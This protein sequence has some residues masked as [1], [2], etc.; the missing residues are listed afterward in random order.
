MF[1]LSKPLVLIGS[2]LILLVSTTISQAQTVSAISKDLLVNAPR[3]KVGNDYYSVQLEY[4]E[5]KANASSNSTGH[6]GSHWRVTSQVT[7]AVES[8]AIS[9]EFNGSVLALHCAIYQGAAYSVKLQLI[10]TDSDTILLQ[11]VKTE[12][13][14]GCSGL[15]SELQFSDSVLAGCVEREATYSGWVHPEQVTGIS[16]VKSG[17]SSTAGIEKLV[18]LRYLDLTGNQLT[19]IDI[20]SNINLTMLMLSDNRLT[21]LNIGSASNLYI[22]ELDHNQLN[23]IDVSTNTSLGVLDLASNRLTEIAIGHNKD[24]YH[25]NLSSNQLSE[26][27]IGENKDLEYLNLSSNRLTEIN[28]SSNKKIR[29]LDLS[30]NSLTEQGIISG[31]IL[32]EMY[33]NQK[34]G[35]LLYSDYQIFSMQRG[36]QLSEKIFMLHPDFQGDLQ[37]LPYDAHAINSGL[38]SYRNTTLDSRVTLDNSFEFDNS[39]GAFNFNPPSNFHGYVFV[40]FG[41][42]NSSGDSQFTT[43]A[44]HVYPLGQTA[45]ADE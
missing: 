26:I 36:D 19:E 31:R 11:L 32:D 23:Q 44:I 24:L 15:I 13:N 6:I 12:K 22:L 8:E 39:S 29:Y 1:K 27:V 17:V 18:A 25:L 5:P 20:S 16:C 40:D 41:V 10:N 28:I 33:L 9:G 37:Y 42:T 43:I 14:P 34:N 7:A 4:M 38:S 2:L 30:S 35:E 3:V 45:D 21:E